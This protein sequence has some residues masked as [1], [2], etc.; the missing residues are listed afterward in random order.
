MEQ[1]KTTVQLQMRYEWKEPNASRLRKP[2]EDLVA[3]LPPANYVSATVSLAA[4][5]AGDF[6]QHT[7]FGNVPDWLDALSEAAASYRLSLS[8]GP[9][10]LDLTVARG[11]LT[12]GIRGEAERAK[13][14]RI[15]AER[16]AASAGLKPVPV[17]PAVSTVQ[18][19]GFR[20]NGS[21][22]LLEDVTASDWLA[23][24][25]LFRTWLGEA[26]T[27][28][29]TVAMK[30]DSGTTQELRSVDEWKKIVAARWDD[31]AMAGMYIFRPGRTADLRVQF[32]DR[33]VMLSLMAEDGQAVQEAVAAFESKLK[34][35]PRVAV[36]SDAEFKGERRRYYTAEPITADWLEKSMMPILTRNPARRTG[37]GGT[38]RVADQEYT[39]Q[40]FDAWTKEVARRWKEMQ[41]AGCWISTSDSRQSLDVDFEREQVAVELRN[42]PGGTGPAVTTFADYESELKLTPAPAKPYQYY[43]FARTYQKVNEWN[44]GSD[45][46]LA[47]AIDKA[48]LAAFGDRRYAFMNGSMTEGEGAEMQTP[49]SSKDEFLARLRSGVPYVSARIYLQGPRGYDLGVQLQRNEK[50]VVLRSSIPDAELFKKVALPFNKI[51]DLEEYE[52][53]N[54]NAAGEEQ[55]KPS[56]IGTWMPLISGVPGFVLAVLALL[57]TTLPKQTSSL[58]ILAPKDA[59]EIHGKACRVE[60]AVT[61]KTL[62]HGETT[63]TP[64]AEVLVTK[65]GDP[66]YRLDT[67]EASSGMTITF[68]SD[69]VYDLTV[70]GPSVQKQNVRVTVKTPSATPTPTAKTP[71]KN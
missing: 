61:R 65:E 23:A 49:F 50:K 52:A 13:E 37:F 39:V 19:S 9:N 62:L 38:F 36:G 28:N 6:E 30:A 3:A 2:I 18:T 10:G 42:R 48:V 53:E 14:L 70:S 26:L 66:D 69:G 54:R 59:T 22:R 63:E 44:S 7:E 32:A 24:V 12:V 27:F 1:K 29:G 40:D 58:E 21:Y 67:P 4:N 33:T 17:A 35:A 11:G 8:Q 46:V 64:R 15:Q 43:R 47:E 20:R 34:V 51:H 16:F 55:K 5:E 41:A 45:L 60:W 71:K 56:K 57:A 25:D 31:L 68:P